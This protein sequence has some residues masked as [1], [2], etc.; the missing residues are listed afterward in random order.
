[1]SVRIGSKIKI[2]ADKDNETYNKFRNKVWTVTHIARNQKEHPGYDS[3]VN[4]ALVDCKGLPVSLYEYEFD[5][6][7]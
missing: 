7:G 4:E 6:V 3:G 2:K 1:M 5:I